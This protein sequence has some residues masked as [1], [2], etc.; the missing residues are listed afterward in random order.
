M[1]NN[2]WQKMLKRRRMRWQCDIIF[3]QPFPLRGNFIK[4][5]DLIK[6]VILNHQLNSQTKKLSLNFI[7][8]FI[9]VPS[10]NISEKAHLS[11]W[12]QQLKTTTTSTRRTAKM[13]KN[14]MKR[15]WEGK[16]WN[17]TLKVK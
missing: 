6:T 3:G 12:T 9:P 14:K 7:I 16:E 17:F 4:N 10:K 15:C 11:Q 2:K 8:Q 5:Q 13:N 1:L